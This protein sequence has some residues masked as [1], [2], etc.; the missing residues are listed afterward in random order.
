M[1]SAVNVHRLQFAF[2]LVF[3]YLFPIL[4]MGLAPLLVILKS[5][6]LWTGNE[7][8]NRSTRFWGRIFG[9]NFAIRVVTG[10]P[11]S[12]SSAPIGPSFPRPPAE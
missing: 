5:L 2:T 10:T 12:S 6:A 3:H 4:T 7:H 1:D 11:W 9:I 8:Y